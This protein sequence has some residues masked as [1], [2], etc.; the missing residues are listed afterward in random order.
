MSNGIINK[1]TIRDGD[2]VVN[3][4]KIEILEWK[5][6]CNCSKNS[7][8]YEVSGQYLTVDGK[9]IPVSLDRQDVE[10]MVANGMATVHHAVDSAIDFAEDFDKDRDYVSGP[11]LT[12]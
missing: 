3:T 6:K 12:R 1:R 7:P 5:Q 2:I 10:R 9:R 8:Q 4:G 11:F